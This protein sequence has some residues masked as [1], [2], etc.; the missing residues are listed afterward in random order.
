MLPRGSGPFKWRGIFD[1]VNKSHPPCLSSAPPSSPASWQTLIHR[2]P[3]IYSFTNTSLKRGQCFNFL[4][5]R[6]S[7]C[8]FNHA[9]LVAINVMYVIFAR[10]LQGTDQRMEVG[11]QNPE[12]GW[13]CHCAFNRMG[14]FIFKIIR[15]ATQTRSE[16]YEWLLFT[17]NI[18]RKGRICI[19]VLLSL[20]RFSSQLWMIYAG[21]CWKE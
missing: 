5:L 3:L 6:C 2:P 4:N 20:G 16:W 11:C 17:L 21:G 1:R 14:I 10:F 8:D 15:Y 13:A 12:W 7:I 18:I 9:R 19:P